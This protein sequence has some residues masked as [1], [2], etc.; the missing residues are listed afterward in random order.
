MRAKQCIKSLSLKIYQDH[1]NIGQ[2]LAYFDVNKDGV[3]SVQ[4]FYEMVKSIDPDL[5]VQEA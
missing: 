2:V 5:T 1:L 3:L 4:E